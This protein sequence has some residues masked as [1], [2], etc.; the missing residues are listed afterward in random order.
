MMTRMKALAMTE[1]ASVYY[2]DEVE[3]CHRLKGKRLFSP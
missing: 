2:Y 3:G 1:E